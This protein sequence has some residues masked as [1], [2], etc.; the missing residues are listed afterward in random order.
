MK[1]CKVCQLIFCQIDTKI[2]GLQAWL[3]VMEPRKVHLPNRRKACSSI[4]AFT[5]FQQKNV[6]SR[7]QSSFSCHGQNSKF[8]GVANSERLS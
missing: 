8:C 2:R 4:L 5:V 1:K 3:F 7:W 6:G